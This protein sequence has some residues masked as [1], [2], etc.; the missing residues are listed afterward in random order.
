MGEPLIGQVKEKQHD[1]EQQDGVAP[2]PPTVAVIVTMI[3]TVVMRMSHFL[4]P[5]HNIFLVF[6]H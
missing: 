1:G 6:S 4:S 3:V 5:L 2:G